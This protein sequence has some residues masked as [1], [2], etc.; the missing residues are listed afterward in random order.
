MMDW[1]HSRPAPDGTHHTVEG[2]PFYG[3]RFDEVLAYHEPGLAP[4]RVGSEAWHIDV[5]GR[6]A[7]AR[8]LHRTFGFY[9]GRAAAV[10]G[11]GWRHLLPDGSDL[12]SERYAWCGNYQGQRCAVRDSEGLYLYLTPEGR[13][14]GALRWRYAGDYRDAIAVV[15]DT[16]GLS[17]HVDMEGV[18]IHGRK[19]LNLDVFHKGFARAQDEEG[20][21]HVDRLG[22]PLSTRRFALVEPFY[23]GQARV[24]R[25]DG[26]LEV[27]DETG[28]KV[29]E[30]RPARRN[31]WVAVQT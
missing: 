21:T 5:H 11:Q 2:T 6:A 29:V 1:R 4:V 28:Q 7:Y 8:R 22:R 18:P 16:S 27:I 24:E 13:P 30:T 17:T 19:F 9:E 31:L 12:Y 15:Q 23:N 20:W 10:D 14:A 26:G 3:A 25:F